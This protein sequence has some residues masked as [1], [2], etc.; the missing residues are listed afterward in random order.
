MKRMIHVKM[1]AEELWHMK[2]EHI[3][4]TLNDWSTL[5]KK[6]CK[7][8]TNECQ[9]RLQR[10][11]NNYTCHQ[12]VATK[13]M[14]GCK[15]N[16]RN[17]GMHRVEAKP[18]GGAWKGVKALIKMKSPA[19]GRLGHDLSDGM[20]SDVIGD[21]ETLQPRLSV[22]ESA[23]ISLKHWKAVIT[24]VELDELE[25]QTNEE[26]HNNDQA[27]DST[28]SDRPKRNKRPP[29][30]YG[31]EDLVS[32]ALLTSS[33]DPST[34]EDAIESSGN[35]KCMEAMVKEMESLSK[36]KTWELTELPKG[37]KPI[38][39]KWLIESLINRVD[40]SESEA[41]TSLDFL[42]NDANE[43]LIRLKSAT[44]SLPRVICINMANNSST[45]G[46][47]AASALARS[48]D[49]AW[50]HACVVP[51]AKNN[52]ICLYCNKL[53]K[54]GGITRLKYH[55]AGI[56]GQVE[57][58][59]SAPDDVKWQMKQLIEDLKKSKEKKRKINAEIASAYGDPID[60]DEEEEV[61]VGMLL[62]GVFLNQ[63]TM[64]LKSLDTS[65][66]RKDAET[67]FDI[68]DTVF[69]EIAH[70]LDL[71]LEN[72]ADRRYFPIVDDTVRKAK[73]SVVGK[74]VSKDVL[75]DHEFWSQCHHIVKITEP[76]VR[77]LRLVDGDEKPVMGYLYEA[78]DRA[79]KE[80]KV[81]MKHKVS[82]YGPYV[83]V[84]DSRWD[85]QLYSHLHAAGCFLNPAIYFR[86]TFTKK[87]EVHKG[88]LAIIMRLVRDPKIQDKISSQ[89]DEYKK[90]IG[91]FGMSLTICQ[92][93]KPNPV[94]WWE[95]FGLG[96]PENIR[97][98][99]NTF[100]PINLDNIDLM[101]EWVAEKPGL[102]D[103]NDLNWDNLNAPIAL[104]NVEDDDE[105]IVLNEDIED[106]DQVVKEN[107]RRVLARSFD[108][109][110]DTSA[111]GFNPYAVDGV[112]DNDVFDFGE[113]DKD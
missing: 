90:S 35:D 91:D 109:S 2:V 107:T 103:E 56:R 74:E 79:K 63:G 108:T 21:L 60:V 41:E 71:M 32:Y 9:R 75:E 100:N 13:V 58:C 55:L 52:T 66:L 6:S 106:D 86:P 98:T 72:I 110:C 16:P 24:L 34:F 29:V 43:A 37:K 112:D 17:I 12:K 49:L 84:I 77:V 4:V 22:T 5:W 64:F 7:E 70:C 28:R 8:T 39:C 62:Q 88:L 67:L 78:M 65:G 23:K 33:E 99:K 27:Q 57:P 95:Q 46:S 11:T 68:F 82:L 30:R 45:I 31:F 3:E 96:T 111:D 1:I 76:L 20:Q 15:G 14:D 36:N 92:R 85:R 94:S 97:R 44:P 18:S 48:E 42:L 93:E 104:V 25:S 10:P 59:K 80:I 19:L 47:S 101:A 73:H 50:A 54:G 51:E 61:E 83:Q 53:I 102:L 38:G 69:Q 113:F 105:V 81:T 26:P 87:S 40:L 89:L